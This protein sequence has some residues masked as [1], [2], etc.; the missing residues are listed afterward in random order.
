MLSIRDIIQNQVRRL[1]TEIHHLK[2]YISL[3]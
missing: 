3:G 2:D 1:T